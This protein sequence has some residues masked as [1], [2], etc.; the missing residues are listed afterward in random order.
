MGTRG[1]ATVLIIAVFIVGAAFGFALTRVLTDDLL[2]SKRRPRSTAHIVKWLDR[3]LDLSASQR[4]TVTIIVDK[5]LKEMRA[6]RQAYRPKTSQ[7]EERAKADIRELLTPE[8]TDRFNR[9]MAKLEKRRQER[10]ARRA[11]QFRAK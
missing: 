6:V 5:T 2:S 4:Q 9:L 3:E 8:Q 1:R 7:I 11:G 10:R